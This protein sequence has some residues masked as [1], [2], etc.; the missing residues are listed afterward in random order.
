MALLGGRNE[1]TN[2]AELG[3][4][5]L[6]L[7]LTA[8]L[9]E[10]KLP[11]ADR[12]QW[13]TG[14]ILALIVLLGAVLRLAH[15]GA[16]SIWEDEGVSIAIARL[17]AYQFLRILWRREANMALYYGL[18]RLWLPWGGSEAYIRSLSVIFALLTLVLV[19]W[20][21][22]RL[23]SAWTGVIAA[24][25]LAINAFH[26]RYSQ[27]ARSYSL[28]VFLVTLS[29]CFLVA[30]VE[31]SS[32]RNWK[33]YLATA[34]LAVY[35]QFFAILVV[36]A[37]ATALWF[38]PAGKEAQNNFRHSLRHIG[39]YTLPIWVFIATTGAG[40]LRWIRRPGLSDLYRFL[41]ALTGNGGNPLL[42]LVLAC[43][44]LLLW[45]AVGEWRR[46]RRSLAAWRYVLV[47]AWAVVPTLATLAGSQ[48]LPA[49]QSRYLII[50]LPAVVLAAAAG[51]AQL[52]RGW[53]IAGLTA[54][55]AWFSLA[56]VRSYYRADFDLAREDWRDATRYILD[57]SQPGDALIFS[58][59]ESRMPFEYYR[60]R[61]PQ[62][63]RAPRVLF[64]WHGERLTYRDFMGSASPA[65]LRELPQQCRRLWVVSRNP[66]PFTPP[67]LAGAGL[68]TVEVA[69]FPRV[70]ITLLSTTTGSGSAT[71][72]N[73]VPAS[74]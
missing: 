40:P 33:G 34:S 72:P 14:F 64:P 53:M 13:L 47:L 29:T 6:S 15:L 37:H 25:L 43:C 9:S 62:G 50:S 12:R 7:Q 61:E 41:L 68:A 74:R 58:E 16:K 30:A 17:P 57:R 20:L 27:E 66:Q 39:L 49:F 31:D 24:F 36:G 26:V 67:Q 69:H 65:M 5:I 54:L 32:P 28:V 3:G 48:L 71:A 23:Y 56:G 8:K 2:R 21:G 51:I 42:L 38:S 35:A 44:A 45:P 1:T 10:S 4:W 59:S 55:M 70:E 46:N 60:G 22:K 63:G 11:A 52:R 19:Y 18:L 73:P